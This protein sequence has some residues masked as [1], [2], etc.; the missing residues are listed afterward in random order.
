MN[1]ACVDLFCGIGGLTHGLKE[2]GIDVRAGIDLDEGCRWSYE[3]NTGSQFIHDDVDS[4]KGQALAELFGDAD[5][6]LLAG[7]APCQPFSSYGNT[8]R[9]VDDRWRLLG[10][11][12]RAVASIRPEFVTM[13]NVPGLAKHDI[14]HG[15]LTSLVESGY[16]VKWGVLECERY[17]VPQMRRRLVLVA[18]KIGPASLPEPSTELPLTVADAIAHTVP[19]EAGAAAASDDPLHVSSGLTPLNLARIRHSRPGGTWRDWPKELVA[20]CHKKPKGKTYPSVYGRMRWDAPSPTITTQCYGFGNGRFGHPEQDRAIS[21]RE[22]ALLQSFPDWWEFVAPSDKVEFA[23]I[24][25]AIGN[26]VP[27]KLGEAIGRVI[28]E[29]AAAAEIS[30]EAVSQ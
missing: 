11:F 2:A 18:S 7:C 9:R 3:K 26:A 12:S 23:P 17:G 27:P 5:M 22:A 15:F 4:V 28:L 24:G 25:R 6:R 14:F 16:S 20:D 19:I 30:A 13:E 29:L 21:L 10:A 1:I 8:R